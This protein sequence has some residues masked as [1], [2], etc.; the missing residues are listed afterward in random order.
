MFGY[1][2]LHYQNFEI[3]KECVDN[4][5]NI[6]ESSP[7]VIVDNCSPNESG[8][9]LKSIYSHKK[10][11]SVIFCD[12]N[13]GFAK[14]NNIGYQFLRNNFSLSSIVVLNNDIMIKDDNFSTIIEHFMKNNNVDVCGPDIVTL[15]GNHQNP[16][17]LK[18]YA[19]K[20]LRRVVFQDR[21]K[22]FLFRSN[23]FWKLYKI[24]KDRNRLPIRQKQETAFNC[25]LHGACIIY[26]SRFIKNEVNAFLPI[27]FM[28]NEEAIL[29]D[30]L[31][32][33][34]Y[35]T[36]YCSDI[37][38]LHM[39]GVSTATRIE[40]EKKKIIFRFKNNLRSIEAQLTERKKYK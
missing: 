9:Q 7:I 33:K 25:I 15:K 31:S 37:T 39:E 10:N 23:F 4:L 26:G 1:V 8:K 5:V 14:G 24:Y 6:S 30:Y 12:E 36:G 20:Y 27:T 34:G 19:S 11:V 13:I 38:I 16:L 22:I 35:K 28:Y 40:D 21:I 17:N 29:Y 2:V 32:Y 18:P 3:T